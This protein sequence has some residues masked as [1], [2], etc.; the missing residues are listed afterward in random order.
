MQRY[1]GIDLGIR[2]K[3]RA[4]VLDGAE[5]RGK[6]FSVEVSRDGLEDLL[7]K[8]TEEQE[9]PVSFVMEPTGLSWLVM[10]AY[11][12]AS[13]HR[14]YLAKPQKASDLRKFIKKHTKSDNIDADSLARLPQL[15]P[16]GV[17]ELHVPSGDET[18]MRRL[19][20]RR[21]RYV[22]E[23][24]SQKRRIH[25]LMVMVNPH[26]MDA[27]NDNKFGASAVEFF[28]RYADPAK[29]VRLGRKRLERFWSKHSRRKDVSEVV[30]RVFEACRTTAEL[31]EPLRTQGRLPFDY[32]AV[33]QELNDELDWMERAQTEAD[34]L[35]KQILE[36]YLRVDPDRT[37]E[38]LRGIGET[39]APTILALV[40]DV[41]RF[42]NERRFVSYCGIAPR[43]KQTGLSDRRMP[44]MKT[45]QRL[46]KKYLYLAAD[47]ARQW[48]PDLAA[49]YTRRYA[50]GDHHNRIMI[51]LARKMAA[52]IYS[53]LKRQAAFRNNETDEPPRYVLR[54]ARGQERTNQEAR[55]LIQEQYTRDKAAPQRAK[56]D[57]MRRGKA[58][59]ATANTEW[60]CKHA[61]DG[62]AV[63]PSSEIPQRQSTPQ[64]IQDT[65]L[66]VLTRLAK[67][68]GCGQAVENLL[69]NIAR[70]EANSPEKGVDVT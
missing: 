63:P 12:S 11:V 36:M 52:R 55:A 29:V 1:V 60:P 68:S 61:T 34:R 39:I 18:T 13:G 5:R 32:E 7:R 48:D 56:Q 58:K 42:H 3:H 17:H 49:Y 59:T 54:D 51:A 28:R 70:D 38:Q 25:A 20:K 35:E 24:A 23:A 41:T 14:V 62:P 43:K 2:T 67:E 47:V 10:S 16:E 31:H 66:E 9:G 27:L 57:R 37:L 33:Q 22:S 21:E 15:D 69:M 26:L 6:P 30:S 40:G 45:G 4:A 64:P 8:S 19:V 50:R 65:L 53:L 46:L 44:I